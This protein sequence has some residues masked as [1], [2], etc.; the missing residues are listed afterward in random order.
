MHSLRHHTRSKSVLG[1]LFTIF[2]GL[3]LLSTLL[4]LSACIVA[5]RA[6]RAADLERVAISRHVQLKTALNRLGTT[7]PS[8]IIFRF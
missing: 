4:I 3:N 5:S 8:P 7:T 1:I 6:E 2:I